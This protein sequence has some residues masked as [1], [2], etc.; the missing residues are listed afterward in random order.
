MSNI[1]TIK[2]VFIILMSLPLKAVLSAQTFQ[3]TMT[4]QNTTLSVKIKASGG[5]ITT[6]FANMEF[7]IRYPSTTTITWGTPVANTTDFP[8]IVIQKND[9]YTT[10]PD[11]GF[12]IVR[13]FLPPG[14][15]TTSTTY[16]NATEYEVFHIT[17][18]GSGSA[19][20]EMMH[21]TLE[22]PYVLTLVNETASIEWAN[23][24]KF[25]GIGATVT[26]SA[27]QSLPLTIVL[28]LELIDFSGKENKDNIQLNWQTANERNVSYFSIEKSSDATDKFIGIGEVK[29]TGNTATPQYYSLLD[30]QPSRLNYYRLKMVDNDGTFQYSKTISFEGKNKSKDNIAFYPNPATHVLHVL[31]NT[32]NYH[33]AT[34]SLLDITGK[35]IVTQSKIGGNQPFVLNVAPFN[36]GIYTAIVIIDGN[37][38]LH[39]V[40][41]SK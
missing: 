17:A 21:Q 13:F 35:V 39:K 11:V 24:I 26:A 29:A 20:L 12:T 3:A 40:V 25:Y 10:V 23:A 27:T 34:V 4:S 9:P 14:T 31:L 6:G 8:S 7:Y 18:T 15:F 36:A 28:P 33:T 19:S 5:N 1:K 37:K 38:S 41:I 16:T 32:E 22:N 30:A 2:W